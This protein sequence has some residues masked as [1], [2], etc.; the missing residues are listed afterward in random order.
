MS[1]FRV[2]IQ[3]ALLA[4]LLFGA[5]QSFGHDLSG[6]QGQALDPSLRMSGLKLHRPHEATSGVAASRLDGGLHGSGDRSVSA[7]QRN[8]TAPAVRGFMSSSLMRALLTPLYSGFSLIG[9]TSSQ[10]GNAALMA[11]SFAPFKPKVRYSWDESFFYAE[12]DNLPNGMP[13]KMVG[14]TSW[15]QQIPLP[16]SYFAGTT[17]PEKDAASLGYGQ[18][19]YWRLPLV[20]TL[21][22]SPIAISQGNFQRGA[23]ALASNGLA[24]FNP[25]NNRGDVSYEIGELDAYGGHCGLADDYH[26]HIIPTHLLSAFGGVLTNDKPVAWALDGYPIY[27]FVEPD[28]NPMATLD[29]D[30]GHDVGNGWGYHYHAI[31]TTATDASHPYGTPQSPYLMNAFHG[32]V[33]N[34]GGQVDGQPEVSAIRASGT[35]G[36]EAKA[37]SGASITQFKNPVALATD[38]SGHLSEDTSANAVAKDDQYLMR[39]LVAGTLYDQ[40]WRIDRAAISKTL[41]VTWRMPSAT[42]VTHTYSNNGNRLTSYTTAGSSILKLPDTSQIADT[43]ATFGE[44]ADYSINPQS[45]TDN[46]NGTVTDNVTGLM[47]QKT[48]NGESTWET[49]L[50][51][52]S[53]LTLGGYKDWRLPT[54]SELFSIFNHNNGNPAAL[55][56]TYFPS[57]PSG[58]AEYWWSS[59][60]YGSSTTSVWCSNSGGGLGGKPK[61]ETLTAGGSYRY[62]ARYVRGASPT[63]A[64][65]Y[66]NNLDG[67]ITDLDTGLMWTQVPASARTWEQAL[68]YAESLTLAGASDWRLPNIKELQTLTDYTL[69]TA[70]SATGIKPSINR[71]MF[72]KSLTGCSTTLGSG[73][74]ICADT[75]GLLVGMPIVDI[76]N[77]SSLYFASSTPPTVTAVTSGT[78]FT[79]SSNALKTGSGLTLKALALPTAYWSST[80]LKGDTTKA[81]LLETGINNSVLASNGPTRNGQGVISYEA[82]TSSYPVFAVRTTSV[83]TQIAVSQS[84]TALTDGVSTVGFSAAGAKAF[85]VQNNGVTSLVLNGVSV[86][87][88]DA[89]KFTLSGAPASGTTLAAGGSLTFNVVFGNASAGT[90][91][92]AALHVASS[93]SSVGAAFDAALSGNIPVIASVASSPAVASSADSPYV[94]AKIT[95]PTNKTLRSTAPVQLT[96]TAGSLTTGTVFSESMAKAAANPWAGTNADNAWDVVSSAPGGIGN[97]QQTSASN[98]TTVGSGTCALMFSKGATTAGGS[99][100]QVTTSGS[101]AATGLTGSTYPAFVEFWVQTVNAVAGYGWTFQLAPS[102]SDFTTRLSELDGGT[103]A[104]QNYHYD[105]LDTDRVSTLKMRFQFTG[106]GTG[107]ST[108][109]KVYIDDIIVK[110]TT[111]IPPVTVTMYDDGLHGDGAA[112]D[113]V[114]G[115]QIPAQALGTAVSYSVAVNYNDSTST[116]LASAGSYTTTAPLSITSSSP[117]PGTTT[118]APYSQTLAASGGTPNYTWS[119]S[120]GALPTG[121]TLSSTGT[122]SGTST[123]AGTFNFSATAADSVG[124]TITKSLTLSVTVPPNILVIL[125]DDQGWADIGYHTASGQVPIST[126]NLNGLLN[127]GIRLE[128]FY[129]TAVC[130]VSRSAMLT[131]R[132]TLRTGTNNGKGLPLQEHLMPQA[133]KA[134][135]YQTYMCG[136]WHLGG[137]INNSN[138]T[139]LNGNS[140]SVVQEGVE[141]AP[142]NRGWD[143]HKGTYGGSINYFTHMAS[144]PGLENVLDWWENGVQVNETTDQQGHGGY[145]TDLL[146]DKAVNLI[147]NRD[148][149]KPMLMYLAFNAMHT[150]VSAPQSYLDKYPTI[151]DPIRKNIAAAVECMD[152]GIG[153]VLGALDAAGITNN[154]IVVFMSD[155]GGEETASA[156]NDPL[157]GTKGDSYDGGVH[158]PAAICYPGKLATGIASNQYVWIGD[159][160]P[161]LCAATGVPAQNT[162]PF[163]GINLW[164]ALQ[165]ISAANPHGATRPVPLVTATNPPLALDTFTDPINGGSKVF[166]V[167]Y[168]KYVTPIK[169]EIFNMT[170]DPYET[171]DLLLGA[172]A[173]AYATIASTLTTDITSIT[174]EVYPPYI[175]PPLITQAAVQGG[176]LSL[177]AP[178]TSYKTPTVQWRKNG[179][180]ISGGTSF[181]QVTDSTGAAVLGV[182]AATYTLSNITQSDA[183]SYDLV[184]SN[185]AGSTTS[186]SGTLSVI[187]AAPLPTLP[188]YSQGGSIT[189][190]WPAVTTATSYTAQISSSA[191]FAN[192]ISTKTSSTP[193]ATFTGLAHG[194]TYYCRTTATDG[195]NVSAFSNTVSTT[196]DATAPAVSITSPVSGTSTAQT[197]VVVQGTANDAISGVASVSVNGVT[198][199]TSDNFAHWSAIVPLAVGTNTI[200]AL[201]SDTVANSG[202]ASVL[203]T[204]NPIVPVISSVS[205]G[206]TA[207]TYLDPVWVTAKVQSGSA[208]LSQVKL[209]YYTSTPV[210]T[211][212]FQE[213]FNITSSNNWNGTGALNSWTTVGGGSLRQSIGTSNNTTSINLSSCVTTSGSAAVTCA[214]TAALWPGMYVTGP[215]IPGSLTGGTLGNTTISSITNGTL[216]MLSQA[217]QATGSGLSLTACGAV[218]TNCV[219]TSG[220]VLVTCDRTT[221]LVNGMSLSGTGLANN[222]T[223]ASVTSGTTF[224][225]NAVPTTASSPS[226]ITITASGAAAEFQTG[227]ANLA[228]TMLT[229]TNP[230]N[231]TGAS[232]Y[233]EFYLQTRSLTSTNNNGWTFQV[234]N[235]GTWNTR[236]S[237]SWNTSAVNLSSCVLNPTGITSGTVTVTCASTSG[238]AVGQ[239]LSAPI[240]YTTCSTTNGS[241]TLS[242]SNTA[243]LAVGMFLT[244]TSGITT[245]SRILA[246][247]TSTTPNKLT[248]SANATAT[249]SG[250]NVAVAATYLSSPTTVSAIAVGGTS[251]TISA[252]AYTNTSATPIA[253]A[254]TNLNHGFQSYHYDLAASELNA[255]T[256]LRFQFS[257]YTPTS[258]S[259]VPRVDVDDI[260]VATTAQ[261]DSIVVAMLDDGLHGDGAAGDGVYG[262]A[263]PIQGGSVTVNYQ[264]AATDTAGAITWSPTS[265]T[266]SYTVNPALT[267]ATFANAEFLSI[268]DDQGVT[269]NMVPI[270]D[271]E[272]Y[273]EYGTASGIYTGTTPVTSFPV[274]NGPIRIALSGLPSNTK[275]F[276]RLRYRTPGQ[277]TFNA[278]GER[279]FRTARPRGSS[280]VF[281][282]TADPHLDFNSDPNL[283]SQAM[284]NISADQP[285]FHIDLGDIFMTD[286]MADTVAGVPAAYGGGFP[287]QSRVNLRAQ[288]FRTYFEQA[289]HS[290]PYF[291]TLGNHEAEYGYLFNAATDKLNNIPAWDLIARKTFF[292]APTPS[293]FYTGNGTPMTYTGGSLGLL[294]DYYAWE[295]GDALFVV[296]DP[297]WNTLTNPTQ[298]NDAWNWSLGKTQYDWLTA[299]LQNSSAKYKFLFM[300]HIIGGTPT[301]ADGVTPNV[302][303]RGGVE[304]ADKYE[305]GGK[306][307]D[308]SAGFASH[309]PGWAMPIHDLLVANKVNVV[310]HGHDH[311]YG[312]QTLDGIVYLECPQPG[313]PNYVTLGSAADGKYTQ[314]VLLPNSGH[315]RVTI[316]PGGATSEYVRAYLP[317]D[318]SATQQNRAVSHSFTMSPRVF[319]PFEIV[320]VSAGVATLRWNAVPNKAYNIQWSADLQNW[321]TIDTVTF[322]AVNTNATYTDSVHAGQTK[323]FYRVSYTP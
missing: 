23:V 137:A 178:F 41:T 283:L 285:D 6:E 232:G 32:N 120:G 255:N 263:I 248:I 272:A 7:L 126:P 292:P 139:T 184:I 93:D 91:Y 258:P 318:V 268:P 68:A 34:Y 29:S 195:T 207:P 176:T 155:N 278:R 72:A 252:A 177:Y 99:Q 18:P 5:A 270:T 50:I 194:I 236:L 315:I 106:N 16:A 305:W 30:G 12:S 273:V 108:G 73:T 169:T 142:Y 246:I 13:N 228:D 136:K 301:L 172:N 310:F 223:V 276:Y 309:R 46:N 196:M 28:G 261:P 208:A 103:H 117:L 168:N 128:K 52:A 163:D 89:S 37:V 289:C 321:S 78:A 75:T 218:L 323:G 203:F 86:D 221:G 304:V 235:G 242:C 39:I 308:G 269:L 119:I 219:T 15:Q 85:T 243:G 161:T 102:G 82:K 179:V 298:V 201:A 222:A 265:G 188:T 3:I 314:G 42:P 165:S 94:T 206:P 113:G 124:H 240:I 302:A 241:G 149:S 290:I 247:D 322:P 27:G 45:F 51:N 274:A 70:T 111:G 181:T 220:S 83:S 212:V 174:A 140:I 245:N 48:D 253:L 105:L 226:A 54:P 277:N 96:Y 287:S 115:A 80:S 231:T 55:D 110:T 251:F 112:G 266:S 88:T 237:D 24:I 166:K 22:T 295:W 17:N 216:F 158:T 4:S 9:A 319:P 69:A 300:H 144:E 197:S 313:T 100:T 67:T 38:G 311:L 296:L 238:L 43:T 257:G 286:K 156:V 293:N 230:I 19:N 204:L 138:T 125:T 130:S 209:S 317:A 53:T 233:V 205:T 74:V 134:A 259:S 234:W 189:V 104:Y 192:V 200:S 191:N 11:A 36:Y 307:V 63:N 58:A 213:S 281:T 44:D 114:Y 316:T 275:H 159:I 60:V 49:A 224:T 214:S 90:T 57:N 116:S 193:T 141:Y 280:F 148:S 264:I 256:K 171:T 211:K 173:A 170:D 154:T 291:F 59:D 84:G 14:I 164:P 26:Y 21:S 95:P 186:A 320:S 146:A 199:T 79:M 107:G 182:Y 10:P 187:L 162:K 109:S 167:I 229:T 153:R 2:S 127:R 87:G 118:S 132:N 145:S 260:V 303:A 121:L 97:I 249:S 244:G 306:N 64:H 190:T 267:D 31:G 294:E 62:S 92:T 8:R 271:Q 151:T 122:L 262:A 101:I 239:T 288:I 185:L 25:K 40:C 143:Y 152:D 20:P 227:T 180:N 1:Q 77:A 33:V 129:A 98:H 71:T 175:G 81:W 279:S 183:A 297:F 35:W 131:G 123:A 312:Y 202:T 198:A 299:T 250:T 47:W 65:N 56:T 133:F 217:A 157:R 147:Q 284:A 254:A 135:G 225:M 282:L 210:V 160:F 66:L 61:T 150:P 76:V 215:N